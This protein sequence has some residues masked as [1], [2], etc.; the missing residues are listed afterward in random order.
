MQEHPAPLEKGRNPKVEEGG[1]C[2]PG[3]QNR[4]NLF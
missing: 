1:R 3:E 2:G 4:E